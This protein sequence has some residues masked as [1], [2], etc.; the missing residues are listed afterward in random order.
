MAASRDAISLIQTGPQAQRKAFAEYAA[1]LACGSNFASAG[2]LVREAIEKAAV[3]AADRGEIVDPAGILAQRWLPSLAAG[4][5]LDAIARHAMVVPA[6]V[7][8][9]GLLA[10]LS[11]SAVQQGALKP[12]S[13]LQISAPENDA[14]KVSVIVAITRELAQ[15]GGDAFLTALDQL[16]A[17]AISDGSNDAVLAAL[18]A[19]AGSAGGEHVAST[20]DA[21]G[22]LRA[23]LA[24]ADTLGQFVVAASP[25]IVA[26]LALRAEA[27]PEFGV[28][29]GTFRPGIDI[30]PVRG[31]AG[32]TIIPTVGLALWLSDLSLQRAEH[33]TLV[34]DDEPAGDS[35]T[36][37]G[38][39]VVSIFQTNSIA[40]RAERH[41]HLV[42]NVETITV[43]GES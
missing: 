37:T 8:R 11:S 16:L 22:D 15:A 6:Q 38:G 19:M 5:L 32:L 26:D 29:G 24:A 23:G 41:F 43:G 14:Q 20:G 42:G 7:H 31:H 40:L 33:A 3:D 27:L 17:S 39:S 28:H 12:L 34:M 1:H 18:D 2:H 9:V 13:K 36:P 10:G 21:I 30:V 25:G 4:S 35:T